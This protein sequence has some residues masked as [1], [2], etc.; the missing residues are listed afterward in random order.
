MQFYEHRWRPFAGIG[1]ALDPVPAGY[2]YQTKG[3]T[4]PAGNY[5]WPFELMLNGDTTESIEG[6][7][8]A[9]ITYKL[10]ATVTRG[11]LAHDLHTYKR[12]R[13]IRTLEPSA[14]EFLHAMS[15]ENIWP[16]KVEYSIM[17]PQKA[18]V[19]GSCIPLEM[20]FTPLLKGLDIGD[21]TMTLIETHDIVYQTNHAIRE[22]KKERKIDSWTITPDRDEH[23]R[24]M[25]DD[26]GQEGW[27]VNTSLSLPKKLSRC[28]QDTNTR[29]IKIR[30]KLKLVVSLKNPDGHASELRATLPL[31]IFISPNMP[32]DEEGNLVR[33]LPSTVS[34]GAAVTAPPSYSEHVLDQ[35][36]E[37][38]GLTALH[39]PTGGRS[40]V[41]S[42]S[43]S[44]SRAASAENLATMFRNNVPAAPLTLGAAVSPALLSSRLQSMSMEQQYL[45]TSWHSTRSV[46]GSRSSSPPR[47]SDGS[48]TNSP[49]S[50]VPL[51]RH[52][53]ADQPPGMHTPEHVDL[54]EIRE[55]CKVP[56]YRTAVKTPVRPLINYSD[57]WALPDYATATS[58]PASPR[59]T[60]AA[61]ATEDGL[62]IIAESPLPHPQGSAPALRE[63]TTPPRP[64]S[65]RRP[66]MHRRRTTSS[67]VMLPFP[68]LFQAHVGGNERE[69]PH[70]LPRE[71]LF[72]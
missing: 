6:L 1:A 54:P 22:H 31:S 28:L 72:A 36:Y 63:P 55:L 65:S 25:I 69:R 35:L 67:L 19:F 60:A 16:N 43:H 45:S 39:T 7:R 48:S 5:E 4:L 40:G 51:T 71:R 18:V 20:R 49:S 38:V 26:T 2:P 52:T 64:R 57:G 42:P 37:G 41:N 14:L 66:A 29:G 47:T 50:S 27:V 17:A 23:W 21:I 56:S 61:P 68:H 62:G 70:L 46:A 59:L 44:H 13:I 12:L 11:K 10:K 32:L 8:E 3:V 24:D 58:A 30:H 53:T 33:Q 34:S 15:V 9:S